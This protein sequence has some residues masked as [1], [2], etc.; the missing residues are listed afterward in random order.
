VPAAG[1]W[2][3][4]GR[5]AG[6]LGA[7]TRRVRTPVWEQVAVRCVGEGAEW[8]E[9]SVRLARGVRRVDIRN[10]VLKRATADKESVHFA[11]PFGLRRPRVEYEITGGVQAA[12]G[13]LVPGSAPHM[14]AVRHWLTLEDDASAVA[15]V[16]GDAPLVQVGGLHLPYAPF[17]PSFAADDRD[18][19][20]VFSWAMNNIWDTNFPAA[21]GGEAAF[22]YRIASAPPGAARRLGMATAA[23]A[24]RP[25]V[26]V[27]C[28]P[29]GG[30]PAAGSFCE[31]E[32]GEVDIVT[33]APSR[34]GHGL[35][36]MLHSLAAEP[37][38]VRLRF[39]LLPVRRAW[40]GS[41]LERDL[42]ELP[43]LAGEATLTVAP[44]AYR[45][46]ALELD[47]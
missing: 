26:A 8:V 2:L 44:G 17:P 29:E 1:Q 35:V 11:F 36:V 6:R 30:L 3:L 28:G 7:V 12:A 16:T 18:S 14:R 47:R 4:G 9:T 39:P 45:A 24:A 10:R 22:R 38:R 27:V 46:L 31:L 23:E 32:G 21:Q 19:G 15:W 13:P 43:L 42:R 41:H 37:A 40:E 34:A 20:T 5:T 25:L 33:L